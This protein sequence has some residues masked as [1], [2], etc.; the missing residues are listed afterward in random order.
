MAKIYGCKTKTI[1]PYEYFGLDSYNNFIGNLNTESSNPHYII[2]YQHKK[3]SI[4]LIMKT[5]IKL[6]KI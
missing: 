4:S 6:V 3:K 2:N 5:V 1:Y